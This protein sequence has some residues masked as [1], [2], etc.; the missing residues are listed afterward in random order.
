M[1]FRHLVHRKINFAAWD[2]RLQAESLIP[3]Y[4]YSWYLNAATKKRWNAIVG[5][6][7]EVLLPLPFNRKLFGLPQVYQSPM[8]QQLGVGFTGISKDPKDL[9]KALQSIPLYYW[10]VLLPLSAQLLTQAQQFLHRRS[11]LILPLDR[12]HEQLQLGYSRS[13]RRRLRKAEAVYRVEELQDIEAL[14]SLYRQQVGARAGLS[15][16]AYQRIRAIIQEC[17]DREQGQIKVVLDREGKVQARA[18]FAGRQRIG[19]LFGASTAAGRDGFA[20]H[21]LLD[22]AIAENAGQA[23]VFDF[24][25]SEI[26]G[27]R[28]FF[29][30]FGAQE[31]FYWTYQRR[32]AR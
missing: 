13:L 18:F 25:G 27:V 9:H 20:M 1:Q 16:W 26:P 22:R 31:E 12:Q 2:T 3:I 10:R 8:T 32:F 4:N 21:Y 19:N 24:E 14:I 6:D 5:G 23:K 29:Q 30:S 15:D 28:A 11:N 17:L 7:Y